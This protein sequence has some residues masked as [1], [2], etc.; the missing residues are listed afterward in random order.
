MARPVPNSLHFNDENYL[1]FQRKSAKL[2]IVEP[3]LSD[4][5]LALY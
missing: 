2:P 4:E 5:R 1:A 3:F